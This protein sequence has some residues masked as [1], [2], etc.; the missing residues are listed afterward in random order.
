MIDDNGF[1]RPT[2]AEIVDDLSTEW[3][4]LFG[5]NAQTGGHS[6]GGVVIR[7][8]AYVLDRLYQLA[9]VV[10]NS[11]FVDSAEGT[12]R[13]ARRKCRCCP[14]SSCTGHRKN[15]DIWDGRLCRTVRD[16]VQTV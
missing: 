8:L 16:V 7:I 6:V 11:Q 15:H 3:R 1:S 12:T 2:Y 14:Q 4:R 5:E 9:E 13:P 10:Y